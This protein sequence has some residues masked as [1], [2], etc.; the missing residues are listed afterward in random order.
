MALSAIA[1]GLLGYTLLLQV[2]R[3]PIF[4]LL[5]TL[6]MAMYFLAS[7]AGLEARYQTLYE[8]SG[9]FMLA[10]MVLVGWALSLVLPDSLALA[11]ILLAFLAGSVLL[12][13]VRGQVPASGSGRPGWFAAGAVGYALVLL[14]VTWWADRG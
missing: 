2:R 13:V 5:F 10:A 6:A 14:A 8:R 12:K 11:S 7:D 4:A 3:G 9:R 1:N